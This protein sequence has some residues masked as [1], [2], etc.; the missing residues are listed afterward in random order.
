MNILLDYFPIILFFTS[1]KLYGI[2]TATTVVILASMLQVSIFWFKHHK[3]SPIHILTCVI[4]I[5]FGGLTLVLKNPIFIKLKPTIV[6]W[7]LAILCIT[8]HFFTK[9]NFFQYLLDKKIDLPIKTWQHINFSWAS[10]FALLGLVNIYMAYS[11]STDIWVNFKLFGVVG[12]TVIF[13]IIQ[14]IYMSKKLN[15][16]LDKQNH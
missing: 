2:Y 6:S 11:Y 7:L 15:E 13:S 12:S 4:L 9:K 5:I 16:T 3:V 1:F 14:S 10:F 8:S